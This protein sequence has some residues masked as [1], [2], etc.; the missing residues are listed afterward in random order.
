MKFEKM[1]RL[2]GQGVL[3]LA[4]CATPLFAQGGS[5]TGQ[6]TGTTG[7][8]QAGDTYRGD[9]DNDWGWVGLLGLAG[10][11]GLL[12]R[13][14]ARDVSTSTNPNYGSTR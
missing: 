11:A 13:R 12:R 10:L 8:A 9:G 14:D 6:G 1:T 2:A 3:A 7:G 5:G 4:L